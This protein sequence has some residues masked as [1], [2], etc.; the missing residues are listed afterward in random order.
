M[1]TKKD[2]SCTI[3]K[4]SFISIIITK[5]KLFYFCLLYRCK[6]ILVVFCLEYICYNR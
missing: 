6:F 5:T 2:G 4:P 1:E 3:Q